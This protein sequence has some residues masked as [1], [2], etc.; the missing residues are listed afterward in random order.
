MRTRARTHARIATRARACAPRAVLPL[1]SLSPSLPPALPSLCLTL[2][3]SATGFLRAGRG[4]DLP[5]VVPEAEQA[6]PA[7]AFFAQVLH[8]VLGAQA[9]RACLYVCA[10]V[11]ACAGGPLAERSERRVWL[12]TRVLAFACGWRG[13]AGVC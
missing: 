3:L 12:H 6:R 7:R 8:P 5:R 1:L 11:G 13:V 9:G 10:R 4:A 2:S